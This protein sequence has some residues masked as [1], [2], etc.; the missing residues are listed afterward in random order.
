MD[1]D[2]KCKL[3]ALSRLL[4]IIDRLRDPGGCPWDREQTEQSMAPFVLEEAYE[5]VDALHSGD[6]GKIREEIGDVMMNLFMICRMGEEAGR[7]DV[8]QAAEA[9]SDK[10]VRRHPHVFG[11]TQVD[12]TGQVLKNWEAIKQQEKKDKGEDRSILSG[13][14]AALPALLRAFRIGEKAARV[15]FEWP[16][17]HGPADKIDEEW[18]E[19]RA[20]IDQEPRDAAR[21][22]R[23]LGDLLFAVVN[24]ARHLDV[25]PETALRK[26]VDRFA[27]RFRH[28]EQGLGERLASS[29]LEEKEALW[30]EA[31]RLEA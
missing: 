11:E 10:L 23:E 31:K 4:G 30:Q 5:V 7:F 6:A 12:G 20:E 17:V 8:A 16:D 13:V 9:I 2:P 18:R 29:S 21:M 15:G 3:P 24:L 25:N 22:E 26:T 1:Q 28:I 19:L 14:P 27:T